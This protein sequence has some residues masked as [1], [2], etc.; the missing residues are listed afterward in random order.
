M[1]G[2][3]H[4]LSPFVSSGEFYI[5]RYCEK[6]EKDVWVITNV[7]FD[8]SK[9]TILPACSW[10]FPSGCLIP[11]MRTGF[12]FT[13]VTWIEHVEVDDNIQ[14]NSIYKDV[15]STGI[16]YGA[17]RWLFEIQRICVKLFTFSP[18]FKPSLD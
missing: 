16:A 12:W 4:V 5:L 7:S 17:E 13:E 15:V 9:E 8:Y 10:R 2:D 14:A 1:Y 18:Y 3:M 6:F 11:A